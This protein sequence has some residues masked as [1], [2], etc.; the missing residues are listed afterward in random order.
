MNQE[1][2]RVASELGD[3]GAPEVPQSKRTGGEQPVTRDKTCVE[4]WLQLRAPVNSLPAG[5]AC[6][7]P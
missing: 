2:F 3:Q 1:N 5:R 4:V 6:S 7:R